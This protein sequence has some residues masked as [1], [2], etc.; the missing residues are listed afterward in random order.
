MNYYHYDALERINGRKEATDFYN[1]LC[2]KS[3]KYFKKYF[4]NY[5]N[6]RIDNEHGFN[7]GSEQVVKTFLTLALN[8]ITGTFFLQENPINRKKRTDDNSFETGNGRLDYWAHYK[9]TSY[10]IEVKDSWIR[11][12]GKTNSF[13]FYSNINQL[14]KKAKLQIHSM[15]SQKAYMIS[16]KMYGL[17]LIIAPIY[18]RVNKNEI[19]PSFNLDLKTREVFNNDALK[20]GFNIISVWRLPNEYLEKEIYVNK[21]KQKENTI[22]VAFLGWLEKRP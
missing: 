15:K 10:L 3:V 22:G 8:E 21:R 14:L 19:T 18:Y 1:Q 20:N 6:R 2:K 7:Y 4:D 17:G 13:T 11:Y 16:D 12:K 5:R 9:R